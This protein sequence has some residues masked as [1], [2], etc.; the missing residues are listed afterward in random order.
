MDRLRLRIAF[1]AV[2]A[3]VVAVAPWATTRGGDPT[4]EPS[5]P[6]P[7]AAAAEP[8]AGLTAFD[9]TPYL[10]QA[11]LQRQYGPAAGRSPVRQDRLPGIPSALDLYVYGPQ[12]EKVTQRGGPD[13]EPSPGFPYVTPESAYV[14]YLEYINSLES[15]L[16]AAMP[17]PLIDTDELAL[18]QSPDGI[19]SLDD[20]Q[21][22][23]VQSADAW[24][25]DQEPVV[26][27]DIEGDV[28][29]Y[30]VQ[31]L[32]WHEIVNDV[33][34]GVP[35]AVTYC[36][37]CNSATTFVREVYGEETT[38]GTSGLLYG[39]AL[40]MYDRTTESLWTHFDGRAVAGMRT[41]AQLEQLASPLLAW[42]DLKTAHPNAH[43]LS[44]ETGWPRA[45]G[46]TPYANYDDPGGEPLSFFSGQVDD[47]LPHKARVV[48]VAIEGLSKAWSWNRLA[49]G[50]ASAT[51]GFVGDN[52]VVILWK[53]GQ[54]S[55]LDAY[56]L[57]DG[58][59]V[60]SV[61][62]FNPIVD[63]RRL[64]FDASDDGFV[65]RETGTTWDVRGTAA[66]GP[67]AGRRLIP[68]VHLDT[69]WFAWSSYNPLTDLVNG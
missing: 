32:I 53:E 46:Y 55:A 43:V 34:G 51:N 21:F 65:D 60:G 39:S 41:R 42:S 35:V 9:L 45:Y 10:V 33:V 23:S 50:G 63:G 4:A 27:L 68:I 31:I 37:L 17:E 5:E 28:R 61:A 25:E 30:S 29:A 19:P 6:P 7:V 15:G 20:P 62:A 36:P 38:F 52:P 8:L 2:F 40:V 13:R 67:L 47:R 3:A 54:S 26:V 22:L 58:R 14:L 64:T 48:G 18:G 16:V 49:T 69:F 1:A 59:D 11:K 12:G 57:S 56:R 44:R 66:A 24:L